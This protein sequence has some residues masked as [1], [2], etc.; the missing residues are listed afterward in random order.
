MTDRLTIVGGSVASLA[1]ALVAARAGRPVSLFLDPAR[2]GGSFGGVQAGARRLDLGV[3]LFELDYERSATCCL[4]LHSFD[5]GRHTHRPFIADIAA[6]I[7]SI[8]PDTLRRAAAPEM[9]INGVRTRCPLMTVDLT[10][11][12]SAL[13]ELDR[14]LIVEQLYTIAPP[15]E[16]DTLYAASLGQH[17][18]RLHALLTE[19]VCAKQYQG[20]RATIPS[21]RRKLWAALFHPR[22]LLEAFT[23]A[24]IGFRPHR[25]F[26]TTASGGAHPFIARLFG[27]VAARPDIAIIPSDPLS[28]L[29]PG[30]GDTLLLR[31]GVAPP[32]AV[33]A[34][35]TVI[36]MPP[37]PLFAA[38][39]IPYAPQRVT[40]SILWVDVPEHDVVRPPSTLLLA[41]PAL[42]A[43]RVSAVGSA[44]TGDQ[45]FAIEFGAAAPSLDAARAALLHTG[46]IRDG[47]RLSEIHRL[48]GPAQSA[49]IPA[50]RSAF[51]MA[52]DRFRA[53]APGAAILG[54][55]R[56]FGWDSLN[57]QITDALHFGATR[58]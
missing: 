46:I 8:L 58:C 26:F 20:W 54:G 49:P 2:L 9:W 5:P 50:N 10:D 33:P 27:A 17:G 47:A 28:H 19:T 16:H 13:S 34:E 36:G 30:P 52:L 22:T 35:T 55:A 39:D 4:P 11:F 7:R 48:T 18:A 41:D 42:A 32:I 3:R 6:F 23:G 37:E 53:L 51:I 21:E 56:R 25:P 14:R 31:F 57:D 24:P 40:T 38:A 1:T 12:P 15:Q 29:A 44:P 45:T 43:F